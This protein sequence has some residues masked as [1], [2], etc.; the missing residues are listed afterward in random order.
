LSGRAEQGSGSGDTLLTAACCTALA[1]LIPVALYQ[2]G[3]LSDLPDPPSSIFD[4]ERIVS[5]KIAHPLGVPDALLGLA[6]FGTTLGLILLARHSPL[7]KK[8][9]GAKLTLDG[10]AAAFNA[11]RQ[12]VSFGKLCSYCTGTALAAGVMAYAGRE[13]IADSWRI[14]DETV[15]QGIQEK[16]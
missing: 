1:T 2:T 13:V 7:A 12:V 4:S 14:A 5:S 6:S 15:E 11:G 16:A 3:V 9:L 8:L 10:A